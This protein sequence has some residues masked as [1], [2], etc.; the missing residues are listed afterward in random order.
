MNRLRLALTNPTLAW[1]WISRRGSSLTSIEPEEIKQ[2]MHKKGA[3]IEAGASDG[4]DTAVLATNF[5]T[6]HIYALEPVK[7]QF[8]TVMSVTKGLENVE[9]ENLALST[10]NGL[11]QMY[12]GNSGYGISGMGSSSLL[13]PKNH[14]TEFPEISFAR[15][16]EVQTVTLSEF[17][18]RKSISFIDLLWL[19]VQ[20]FEMNLILHE[21]EFIREYVNLIHMEVSRTELYEG[22]ML[23]KEVLEKMTY[24]GFT[25][26]L[27]RVGRISGNC[28]F[29]NNVYI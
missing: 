18:R 21:R 12:V 5:K 8:E 29:Q 17:C 20:G 22:M 15:T 11:S 1:R 23:Y 4:T 3:I 9:V 28:L 6:N 25:T 2:L 13:L 27:K 26:R 14:L 10:S 24:L 19:D 7:S 16:E